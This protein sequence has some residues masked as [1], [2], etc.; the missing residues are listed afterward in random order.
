MAPA[1]HGHRGSHLCNAP[2]Y[3]HGHEGLQQHTRLAFPEGIS[4]VISADAQD[5]A[6]H[7]PFLAVIAPGTWLSSAA[8]E[9]IWCLCPVLRL[10]RDPPQLLLVPVN[11]DPP[12]HCHYGHQKP[13][14]VPVPSRPCSPHAMDKVFIY[15][16]DIK[17]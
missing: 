16:R 7:E 2:T 12:Q 11:T 13:K 10:L 5:G 1:A 4:W 6:G 3:C 17:K 15:N 9:G 14:A 8:P